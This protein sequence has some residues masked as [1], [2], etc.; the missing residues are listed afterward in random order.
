M[1]LPRRDGGSQTR[2]ALLLAG[3][4]GGVEDRV[5]NFLDTYLSVGDIGFVETLQC[6]VS[7]RHAIAA[8]VPVGYAE[9]MKTE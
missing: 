1:E 5:M 3:F 7:T 9:A 8:M 6:S 4:G 2:I